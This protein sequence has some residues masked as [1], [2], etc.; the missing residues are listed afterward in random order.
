MHLGEVIGGIPST[1]NMLEVRPGALATEMP[2]PQV[3]VWGPRHNTTKYAKGHGQGYYPGGW[4][5][6]GR[7]AGICVG[8]S[9]HGS[10]VQTLHT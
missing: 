10:K 2:A 9:E 6:E 8:T 4:Q 1:T 5:P 7:E 3:T